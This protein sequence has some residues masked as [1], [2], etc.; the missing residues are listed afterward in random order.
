MH[1]AARDCRFVS[2]I[3]AACLL[4]VACQGNESQYK[5]SFP[6]FGTLVEKCTGTG[7]PGDRGC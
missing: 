4:L 2:S 5:E 7:M 6:L 1:Q 3:L